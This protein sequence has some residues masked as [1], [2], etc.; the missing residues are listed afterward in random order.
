M[1]MRALGRVC[2]PICAPG[3]SACARLCLGA[4][5]V[6]VCSPSGL[7]VPVRAPGCLRVPVRART[8]CGCPCVPGGAR[9]AQPAALT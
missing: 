9:S 8:V 5:Q 7:R 4:V 3:G 1:A 2:E 6:P